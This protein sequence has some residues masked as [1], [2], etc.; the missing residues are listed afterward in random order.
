MSWTIFILYEA[1]KISSFRLKFAFE[2]AYY[3][4]Y[5]FKELYSNVTKNRYFLNFWNMD[6][7]L[8]KYADSW[9][10]WLL[11]PLYSTNRFSL[12]NFTR[13]LNFER[14]YNSYKVKKLAA[15]RKV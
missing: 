14:D 12:K 7:L 5:S 4:L 9:F 10:F 6:H 11:V 3:T 2:A 1:A 13:I 8:K 15:H